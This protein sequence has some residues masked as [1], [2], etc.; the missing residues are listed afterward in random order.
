MGND[1][2]NHPEYY[3]FSGIECIDAIASATQG[4]SGM[5]AVCTGQVIKYI[6]RWK[7]KNGVEDLEKAQWY[8]DKLI[9]LHTEE[10]KKSKFAYHV[11]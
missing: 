7:R 10:P 11:E 2:I 8:L 3:T 6:W 4:L 1:S 5:D 9:K